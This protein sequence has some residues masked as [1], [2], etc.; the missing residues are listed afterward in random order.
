MV[1]YS[2]PRGGLKNTRRALSTRKLTVGFLG[3]SITEGRVPHNWPQYVENWFL[4]HYPNL[5][6]QEENIALGATGS[7]LAML[8][9][10]KELLPCGCDLIFV[11][12]AV[13]DN[14]VESEIRARCREGLLRRLLKEG[15]ADVVVVYTF[16]QDMY[17]DMEQNRMP[18]SVADFEKLA[19]HYALP[20]VWMAMY[21]LELVRQGQM[22]WEEWLPDGLHPQYA[23]SRRYGEAVAQLLEPEL[24][25][26]QANQQPQKGGALLPEPVSPYN[27]E[28]MELIPFE[29]MEWKAPFR[30]IRNQDLKAADQFLSTSAPGASVTIPFTG[31]GLLLSLMFGTDA[32]EFL[33]SIDGGEPE[34][35]HRDRPDWCGKTGWYRTHLPAPAPFPW[36]RKPPPGSPPQ[37][38]V[39]SGGIYA[40]FSGTL[41]VCRHTLRGLIFSP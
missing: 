18:P 27:W 6:L 3:G 29:K 31:T 22:K 4:D 37:G 25:S 23:G 36:H 21:A 30:L 40:P 15:T 32:C 41:S 1:P 26:D 7:D 16:C 2:F 35:S 38:I 8:R 17:S 14:G 28:N 24:L 12:Y 10:E 5:R 39:R 11:E 9:L 20:S 33:C 19:E 13:N 34:L